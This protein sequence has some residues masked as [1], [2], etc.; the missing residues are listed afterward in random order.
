MYCEYYDRIADA[1]LRE[2]QVQGWS[3][4]KKQALIEETADK[5][6]EYSHNYTQ[7]PLSSAASAASA[8]SAAAGSAAAGS[9]V[10]DHPSPE[11]VEGDETTTSRLKTR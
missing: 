11:L 9:A 5:L 3:R 7:Y 2:K 4:R 1:F 8:G 10:E 6:I